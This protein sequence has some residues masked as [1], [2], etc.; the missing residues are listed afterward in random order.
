MPE[1]PPAPGSISWFDL[2]VPDARPVRDFYAAVVGWKSTGFNMGGI[3]G[4]LLYGWMMD[5]GTPGWIFWVAAI[6]MAL[7]ALYGFVSDRRMAAA[8]KVSGGA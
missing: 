5:R 7:T 6:F 8:S 1:N 4:P 2:T 3:I